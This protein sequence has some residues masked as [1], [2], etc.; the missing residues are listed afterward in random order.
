[1]IKRIA[2]SYKGSFEGIGDSYQR[3]IRDYLYYLYNGFPVCATYPINYRKGYNTMVFNYKWSYRNRAYFK[4]PFVIHDGLSLENTLVTWDELKDIE[5][6]YNRLFSNASG[7]LLIID[8]LSF[9]KALDKV[10]LKTGLDR[11]IVGNCDDILSVF[12]EGIRKAIN[13]ERYKK[14][15]IPIAVVLSKYDIFDS[16]VPEDYIVK[17]PSP[18]CK[19]SGFDDNDRRTVNDEIASL[20][21]SWGARSFTSQLENNYKTYSYFAVS[22]LGLDNNPSSRRFDI[23]HPHRIED[24]ILWL[25]KEN[26]IIK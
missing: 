13:S 10:E 11:S 16:L 3:Y 24:P 7:I 19:L 12:T 9:M 4:R 6:F 18:H 23:P 2:P 26:G 5:Y 25:M 17:L 15:E 14:I 1:M 8:P 20:L 21:D 22:A